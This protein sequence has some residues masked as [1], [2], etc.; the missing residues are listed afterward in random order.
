VSERELVVLGTASQTPTRHR[1]HNGYL[2]RWDGE[3]VLF[4]PGEGTQRQM[5]LAGVS[6]ASVTRICITHFHGDHCLGLPGMIMR[7]ALDE[8]RRPLPVHYPASGQVYFDRLRGASAGQE[9]V[10]V[11]GH[12]ATGSGVVH[13][14]EAFTILCAPLRHRVDTLGWRL[15]ESDGRRMLPDRL[16]AFGISGPDVGRL[17]AA[18]QLEIDGRT[19]RLDQVS[20]P[21]QGQSFA[22]V[23]DTAWCEE[24]VRL[25]QGADLLVCESTF[26]SADQHLATRFGHLT[27]REAGRLA[28][29]AGVRRLV[30]THFSRR[31]HDVE[32]FAT[33]AGE[34]FD[35]IVVANDLDR[36][37]VPERVRTTSARGS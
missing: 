35:D 6:A 32:A 23:M 14:S 27:A 33:E 18:G 28:A 36:I 29:R 7:A 34:E 3:G 13:S 12:P 9:H 11:D 10:A 8:G 21:R 4:D 30:L 1:N 19:V 22:F 26:L 24:A 5:T 2:L 20:E 37:P 15:Q 16:A 31:Y 17:Q 25:A